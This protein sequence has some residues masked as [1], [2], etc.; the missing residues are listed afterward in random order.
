[1]STS[2][3]STD[4]DAATEEDFSSDNDSLLLLK[5][6]LEFYIVALALDS[7]KQFPIQTASIVLHFHIFFTVDR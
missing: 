1:M 5:T 3:S 4:V 6:K 7:N 2:E